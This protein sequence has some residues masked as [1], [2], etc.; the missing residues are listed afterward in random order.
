MTAAW[1]DCADG[2]SSPRLRAHGLLDV[3]G[4]ARAFMWQSGSTGA[5]LARATY[6]LLRGPL[7]EGNYITPRQFGE[8]V[9]RLDDP[10]SLMPSAMLWSAWGRRA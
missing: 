1:T 3:T 9:A 7:I 5:A 10:D 6:E 4:E 8:D 2:D